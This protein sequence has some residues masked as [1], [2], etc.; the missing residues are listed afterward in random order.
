M[1]ELTDFLNFCNSKSLNKQFVSQLG[2]FHLWW[3]DK[4]KEND[5]NCCELSCNTCLN[6][7]YIYPC[8]EEASIKAKRVTTDDD[9]VEIVVVTFVQP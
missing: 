2:L 3:Q 4:Q 7:E 5:N 8:K 9:D 6:E 1:S